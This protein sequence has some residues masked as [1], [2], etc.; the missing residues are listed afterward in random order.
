[1]SRM[2][3]KD[4]VMISSPSII[5]RIKGSISYGESFSRNEQ[6]TK[7]TFNNLMSE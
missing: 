6:Y 7:S 4:N 3:L 2:N 1:M 5:T